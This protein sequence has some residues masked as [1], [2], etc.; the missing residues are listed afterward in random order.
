MSPMNY[1]IADHAAGDGDRDVLVH[2]ALVQPRPKA[3]LQLDTVHTPEPNP[4][5]VLVKVAAST[6]NPFDY[7]ILQHAIL[8]KQWPWIGGT[9]VAGTVVALGAGVENLKLDDRIISATVHFVEGQSVAAWQDYAIVRS[10]LCTKIPDDVPFP[11]AATIPTAFLTASLAIALDLGLKYP[12][13]PPVQPKSAAS[14]WAKALAS[15]GGGN[16]ADIEFNLQDGVIEGGS[17]Y[18][19]GKTLYAFT[20]CSIHGSQPAPAPPKSKAI[21]SGPV[22]SREEKTRRQALAREFAEENGEDFDQLWGG[23]PEFTYPKLTSADLPS[24]SR[25]RSEPITLGTGD[26]SREAMDRRWGSGWDDPTRARPIELVEDHITPSPRGLALVRGGG[27][28]SGTSASGSGSTSTGMGRTGSNE[29]Y[30]SVEGMSVSLPSLGGGNSTSFLGGSAGGISGR[31]GSGSLLGLDR[32]MGFSSGSTRGRVTESGA[33]APHITGPGPGGYAKRASFSGS[34]PPSRLSTTRPTQPTSARSHNGHT[35]TPGSR[36]STSPFRV[37]ATLSHRGRGNQPYGFHARERSPF[38]ERTVVKREDEGEDKGAL[39]REDENEPSSLMRPPSGSLGSNPWPPNGLGRYPLANPLASGPYPPGRE[40]SELEASVSYYRPPVLPELPAYVMDEPILVWGGGTCVG[41]NALQL[42]KR[43]GYTCLYVV[44]AE[45][46]WE[47]LREIVPKGTRFFDY[48]SAK[49]VEQIRAALGGREL[50]KVLDAVGM[51]YTLEMV[52]QLVGKGGRV[53]AVLPVNT[54]MSEGVRVKTTVFG[55]CHD[56]DGKDTLGS[57]FGR[58][59]VW[60]LLGE[61]LRTRE[62]VFPPMVHLRGGMQACATNA[63]EMMGRGENTGKRLVFS[64]PGN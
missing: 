37:P 29:S 42:L 63:V 38:E 17:W 32:G 18:P 7:K 25:P 43:A 3:P 6:M 30:T 45:E 48:R 13:P 53:A 1:Y 34:A 55:R 19:G 27:G 12:T 40:M 8:A 10:D 47:E 54:P 36:G 4:G 46:R 52:A 60:P 49:V 24:P 51:P 58:E 2:T 23:G 35:P 14:V 5:H 26:L 20:S 44:C 64:V 61:L 31:R 62:Y 22:Q 41:R 57:N 39:K 59:T 56:H 16:S 11:A 9:D 15:I 33:H 50:K 21:T 28:S